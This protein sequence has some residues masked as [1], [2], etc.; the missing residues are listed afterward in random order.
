MHSLQL[1]LHAA[2]LVAAA[3]LVLFPCP[4][5]VRAYSC[6]H[7]HVIAGFKATWV[8]TTQSYDSSSTHFKRQSALPTILLQANT[9]TD[10]GY[11]PIRI[12]ADYSNIDIDTDLEGYISKVL[13]PAALKWI[14]SALA[15][16][17]VQGNLTL[18]RQC[19][20][21]YTSP[22]RCIEYAPPTCG[23]LATIPSAHF[24]AGVP[25]AD[26][27]V[28]V[29]NQPS[30][31]EEI[32]NG[33][34]CQFDQN[35]RPV[36]G[37]VN[38]SP[39]NFGKAQ[40]GTED[41]RYQVN[42]VVHELFHALGFS[43]SLFGQWRNSQGE[44]YDSARE[45]FGCPNLNGVELEDQGGQ[46]TAG[47]HWEKR[48]LNQDFMT[49]VGV[50]GDYAAKSAVTLAAMEDSG[51]YRANYSAAETL[52]WGAGAG[53]EFTTE[54]CLS[55]PGPTTPFSSYFCTDTSR[56]SCT[57]GRLARGNCN[58]A[59]YTQDLPSAYQYFSDPTRGG[60]LQLMD[61]CPYY[62]PFLGANR[63]SLCTEP[64]NQPP[65]NY[66]GDPQSPIPGTLQVSIKGAW[67]SCPTAGGSISVSGFRG[68]FTCPPANEM[69]PPPAAASP[70]TSPAPS[71]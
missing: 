50:Y 39:Q 67:V 3:T 43:S 18:Q 14:S 16:V 57:P 22:F 44:P 13:M 52:Y 54:A 36:A 62:Q 5:Q 37:G 26:F 30:V 69:C 6:Q 61:F 35:G 9:T 47:S 27:I 29:T 71:A 53:C 4:Q 2:V 38:F 56:L 33:G 40:N 23:S 28:Y 12:R 45:F 25:N 70:S 19:I 31:G 41:F 17:P 32:A 21:F 7:D 49:G 58:L 46:G 55:L 15:V 10:D 63:T 51:W 24:D 59:T 34:T 66:W 42:A 68:A 64:L 20:R 48:I 11:R 1:S 65:V 8:S 60:A